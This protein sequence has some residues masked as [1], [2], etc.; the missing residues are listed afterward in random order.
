MFLRQRPT[1]ELHFGNG[2]KQLGAAAFYSPNHVR[3]ASGQSK[4]QHLGIS[5]LCDSFCF[6]TTEILHFGNEK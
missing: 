1:A 2:T 5:D 3:K 6:K 4:I